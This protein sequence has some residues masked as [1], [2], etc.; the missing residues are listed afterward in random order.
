[1]AKTKFCLQITYCQAKNKKNDI[2]LNFITL[3]AAALY[4]L[5]LF[6]SFCSVDFDL[7]G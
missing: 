6:Y 7:Y 3:S 1:M 4:G 2:A 5:P